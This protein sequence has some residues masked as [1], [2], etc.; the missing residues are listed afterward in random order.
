V[1]IILVRMQLLLCLAL[2]C[3]VAALVFLLVERSVDSSAADVVLC[4]RGGE[5]LCTSAACAD[6]ATVVPTKPPLHI[7]HTSSV[8]GE[9]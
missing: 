3:V 4:V 8:F 1:E 5:L 9:R 2:F 6:I 7:R